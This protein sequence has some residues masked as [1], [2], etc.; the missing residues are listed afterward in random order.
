[1]SQ[2]TTIFSM[3]EEFAARVIPKKAS[4]TQRSEM[5]KAFYAGVVVMLYFPGYDLPDDE[6]VKAIEAVEKET[7]DFFEAL[8]QSDGAQFN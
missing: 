2:R 7:N 6:A 1:M 5:Q 8:I 4:T 3:W